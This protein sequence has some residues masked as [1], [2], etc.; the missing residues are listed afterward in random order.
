MHNANIP[1]DS[2]AGAQVD[3]GSLQNIPLILVHLVSLA[4]TS[5]THSACSI[6]L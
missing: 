4:H 5:L 2:Q 3:L 6:F 1:Q